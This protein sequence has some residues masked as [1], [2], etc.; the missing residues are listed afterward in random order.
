MCLKSSSVKTGG[1]FDNNSG[2]TLVSTSTYINV[3]SVSTCYVMNTVGAWRVVFTGTE[4]SGTS[5]S[6]TYIMV[7]IY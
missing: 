5:K 3:A 1:L 4:S 6:F 7:R 2:G